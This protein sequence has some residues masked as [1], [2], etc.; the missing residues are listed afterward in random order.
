[1][2]FDN[3]EFIVFYC[4]STLFGPLP[5]FSQHFQILRVGGIIDNGEII[6]KKKL[7]IL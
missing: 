3:G 4:V 6:K 1:M 7:E 2:R 5:Y